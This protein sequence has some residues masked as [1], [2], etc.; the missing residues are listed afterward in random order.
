MLVT[1]VMRLLASWWRLTE[2]A[3]LIPHTCMLLGHMLSQRLRSE[4]QG[5]EE[6]KSIH[7]GDTSLRLEKTRAFQR[8]RYNDANNE[9]TFV[10]TVNYN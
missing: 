6:N 8:K 10:Q 1:V 9:G 2:K 4:R 7:N 3:L 5:G